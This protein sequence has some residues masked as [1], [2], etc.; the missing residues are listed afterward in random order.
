MSKFPRIRGFIER[1]A[2]GFTE[3]IR[4]FLPESGERKKSAQDAGAVRILEPE[5]VFKKD[6]A[7]RVDRD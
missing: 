6:S 3:K 4:R 7:S 5:D 2:R 1:T